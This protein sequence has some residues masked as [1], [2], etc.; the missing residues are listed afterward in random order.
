VP[1][2]VVIKESE[3]TTIQVKRLT[4]DGEVILYCHSSARAR[5]ET[6]MRTRMQ[7]RFEEGLQKLAAGL[8]QPRG[9][10]NYE[11]ILT[12]LGR[13]RERYPTVARFYNI[14]LQHHQGHRRGG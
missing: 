10:K 12:R 8:A 7:Q 3:A 13:L 4:Q 6:A 14:Q 1:G 2:L 5:K 9:C 11:K